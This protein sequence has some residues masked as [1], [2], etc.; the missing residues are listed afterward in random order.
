MWWR[1]VRREPSA[2]S[3]P[4]VIAMTNPSKGSERA[5]SQ[6]S[7]LPRLTRSV[8]VDL[9]LWM[10]IFGIVVGL[11]FPLME[12][13]LGV[14]SR[15]EL[16]PQTFAITLLAGL[17]VAEVNFQ[18][19]RMV[20]ASRLAGLVAGM[21]DVE[22][23]LVS[24]AADGNWGACDPEECHVPIDSSD[25][26]GDAAASF[27]RLV[28]SLASTHSVVES[29]RSISQ[30]L[31][32]HLDLGAMALESL[33]QIVRTTGCAAACLVVV[34]NGRIAVAG[35]IGV[36]EPDRLLESAA[37]GQVLRTGEEVTVHLP[38][39]VRISAALVDFTPAEVRVLPLFYGASTIGAL[40][41][42]FASEP[43]VEAK[44]VL[45]ASMPNLAVALN[46]A[47]NH[48]ALQQ[49]A[50]LDP[51]TGV[52]NRRF[53]LQRLSEEF[54]RSARS[55]DPLGCLIFDLDHFKAVNDTYGHLAGDQ[56][57][58][59][60]CR[61]ARLVMREGDVLIRYGGEEFL[62]VLPGAGTT[63]LRQMAERLRH[64]V[65]E[66]GIVFNGQRLQV[67]ISLGGAGLPND[68]I[69]NP[70]ELIA[71]ADAALYAAKEAGRDRWSIAE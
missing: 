42:G 66:T 49:V 38:A 19:A 35:C 70:S 39:D 56:V 24:A 47:M 27:N 61:S 48:E 1:A 46:N 51:L 64:A 22:R 3:M 20:V 17:L 2:R 15:Y 37:L 8:L 30:A 44:A 58:Q 11:S 23:S 43:E 10:L 7:W 13:M 32:A 14:P 28:E 31:A 29:V 9:H 6:R 60:V 68:R 45:T 40:I 59:A 16:R 21:Q 4:T 71:A 33:G 69:G 65:N 18:L 57:L 36:N 62:I 25:S 5:R 63:D 26:L 53:G 41:V 12:L 67:T 54:S 55:G 52:Y 50:A 34:R